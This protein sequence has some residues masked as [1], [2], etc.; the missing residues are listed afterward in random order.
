MKGQKRPAHASSFSLAKPKPELPATVS[1]S[2]KPA[3]HPPFGFRQ[4]PRY[5][6][7]RVPV[8]RFNKRTRS[9]D[10]FL[11]KRAAS[12][13]RA[14][15]TGVKERAHMSTSRK[16]SVFFQVEMFVSLGFPSSS[17]FL[18]RCSSKNLRT[19]RLERRW[20]LLLNHLSIPKVSHHRLLACS[21]G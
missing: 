15:S 3:S 6:G 20:S 10:C 4:Q 19:V 11:A 12:P 13:Q 18:D 7:R 17:S 14:P 2:A 8:A 21:T 5:R 1:P 9:H 16:R